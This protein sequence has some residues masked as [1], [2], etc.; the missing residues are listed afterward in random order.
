MNAIAAAAE[1]AVAVAKAYTSSTLGR[2]VGLVL[3][4]PVASALS[5]SE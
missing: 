4:M 2:S 1:V 5:S 3:I